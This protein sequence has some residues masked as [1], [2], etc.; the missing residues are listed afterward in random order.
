MGVVGLISINKP[1]TDN[2]FT[3]DERWKK[4]VEWRTKPLPEGKYYVY[5]TKNKGGLGGV[6]GE[7]LITKNIRYSDISAIPHEMILRGRVGVYWLDKY[8][9]NRP[10]YANIIIDAKR[11]DKLY[12]LRTFWCPCPDRSSEKFL[13]C[14]AG[15]KSCKYKTEELPYQCDAYLKRPPQS[16]CR[17]DERFI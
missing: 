10:L 3:L 16:W 9:G 5:E 11:F 17:V 1:N 14:M 8:A 4:T 15:I 2:I 13:D 7:I 6:I 12:D